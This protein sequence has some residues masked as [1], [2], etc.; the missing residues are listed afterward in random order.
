MRQHQLLHSRR[1]RHLRCLARRRVARLLGP[2]LLF[3]AERGLVHQEIRPL[4]RIH[5]R[6]TGKG[7]AR[8]YDF[9]PGTRGPYNAF[10]CDCTTVRQRHR[11]TAL[12]LAPERTFG[13]AQ[14]LGLRRIES[15][16]P[17]SL[18]ECI[19]N[20]SAAA[21]RGKSLDRVRVPCPVS[22]VPF[23]PSRLQFPDLAPERHPFHAEFDRALEQPLR[24]F[25]AVQ[26]DRLLAPLQPQGAQ[27]A[28]HPE[29]MIGVKVREKDLGQGKAHAV[30]HHLALGAFAA[31]EQQRLP[32]AHQGEAG[33]V[34]L[35]GGA[36]R[37]GAEK[38]Q[39]QHAREYKGA[40]SSF[41]ARATAEDRVLHA[42]RRN[43]LRDKAPGELA[44]LARGM[45]AIGSAPDRPPPVRPL[46]GLMTRTW[47]R[48]SRA[49]VTSL[50]ASAIGLL[51]LHACRDRPSAPTAPRAIPIA[52][53]AQTATTVISPSGDTYLNINDINYATDALLNLYT[54]PNDTIA[55]AIVMKFDLSS[56]PAGATL[57][58]ATLHLYLAASDASPD[59][60]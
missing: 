45:R 46:E 25:G 8:D 30:A 41:R 49:L 33:D 43:S 53:A 59:P 21:L 11:L 58:S 29:K 3:L 42:R 50:G 39:A 9:T 48:R 57:S 4:C 12:Q 34:A 31:L 16:Q 36:R 47:S 51:L 17:L 15:P 10:R 22:R 44:V 19:A 6:R 20:G 1:Q 37:G 60:T 28:D 52:P 35:D 55:N 40:G 54:W 56:I 13:H 26:L 2:I 32:L 24:A 18:Y 38:R 7:V 14:R 5:D 27:Q 23:D